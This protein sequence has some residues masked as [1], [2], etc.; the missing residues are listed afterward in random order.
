MMGLILFSYPQR[1]LMPVIIVFNTVRTTSVLF[2]ILVNQAAGGVILEIS[3]WLSIILIYPFAYINNATTLESR[4]SM[5]FSSFPSYSCPPRRFRY[6][7][8]LKSVVL[9]TTGRG[10]KAL[11]KM[12]KIIK[13]CQKKGGGYGRTG[14]HFPCAEKDRLE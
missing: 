6:S 4:R 12:K 13:E 7:L 8:V 11:A 1:E 2:S 5:G 9:K 14:N 3:F 10:A